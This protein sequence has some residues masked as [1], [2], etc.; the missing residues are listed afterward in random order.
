MHQKLFTNILQVTKVGNWR[1]LKNIVIK[2]KMWIEIAKLFSEDMSYEKVKNQ[3][4]VLSTM[5]FC[6]K[7][8]KY[9]E[10]KITVFKL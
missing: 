10:F 2:K 3:W 5:L 7:P 8:L 9:L 4:I 1:D 6:E